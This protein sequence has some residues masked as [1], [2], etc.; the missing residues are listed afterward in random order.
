[1]EQP[2]RVPWRAFPAVV[3]LTDESRTRR[4]PLY[5]AAKTGDAA[6]AALLVLALVDETGMAAVRRLIV[7]T[8]RDAAPMLVSVHAYENEGVMRSRWRWQDCW[9][10]DSAWN[11]RT[12]SC[13]AMSCA[14]PAR[15]VSAAWL[16]KPP[17]REKSPQAT[18]M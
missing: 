3:L 4:H 16:D 14:T 15:T 1:M 18:N 9:D 7:G 10:N 8:H 11:V 12:A 17:S 2:P 6:S 5:R 13:K